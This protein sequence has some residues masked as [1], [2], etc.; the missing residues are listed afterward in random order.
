MIISTSEK[1]GN[2][3]LSPSTSLTLPG[4]ATQFAS[5]YYMPSSQTQSVQ[6][7]QSIRISH[8]MDF[9]VK[10]GFGY[11]L[12]NGTV[13]VLFNDLTTIIQINAFNQRKE[14]LKGDKRTDQD[15]GRNIYYILRKR[16]GEGNQKQQSSSTSSQDVAA[17]CNLDYCPAALEKKAS[18]FIKFK[19]SMGT[20]EKGLPAR[21]EQ[22]GKD[23]H[24]SE[25]QIHI[26]KT[27]DI[28]F[29]PLSQLINQYSQQDST[30]KQIQSSTLK[31][32]SGDDS[33]ANEC[34]SNSTVILWKFIRTTDA[35]A[36][37]LTNST[38]QFNFQDHS[39]FIL[40][41]QNEIQ[42]H[43]DTQDHNSGSASSQ[44]PLRTTIILND[45]TTITSQSLAELLA[46]EERYLT[47]R[48]SVRIDDT[49]LSQIKQ[50][51]ASVALHSKVTHVKEQLSNLITEMRTQMKQQ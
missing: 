40:S 22:G 14:S 19:G 50:R 9:T 35:I 13:G 41:I 47:T 10:Y 25:E 37:F 2:I 15:Q 45:S 1:D 24:Q 6:N 3:I 43:P 23:K 39:K 8:W 16:I 33:I 32:R 34:N 27:K 17:C 38:V 31:E 46:S 36:F 7:N 18:L 48:E 26:D 4:C 21:G 28:N 12:S 11:M 51:V 44:L 5:Q 20:K 30:S 29:F 42:L 49:F